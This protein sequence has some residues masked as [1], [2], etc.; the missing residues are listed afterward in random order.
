M[1][2]AVQAATQIRGY[3]YGRLVQD[4][5]MFLDTRQGNAANLPAARA[6]AAEREK[7]KQQDN[8][9]GVHWGRSLGNRLSGS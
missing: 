3:E 1:P 4:R 5:G 7:R 8:G 6:I 9:D 2:L